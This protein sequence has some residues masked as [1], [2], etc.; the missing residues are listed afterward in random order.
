VVSGL[1]RQQGLLGHPS[2]LHA[3]MN[4]IKVVGYGSTSLMTRNHLDAAK[5]TPSTSMR[6]RCSGEE[7]FSYVIT[8]TTYY[9]NRMSMMHWIGREEDRDMQRRGLGT[10]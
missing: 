8:I 2:L 7:R 3:C 9:C 6:T 4:S 1:D 5:Q 10:V